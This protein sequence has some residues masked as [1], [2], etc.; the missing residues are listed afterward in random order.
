MKRD[1]QIKNTHAAGKSKKKLQYFFKKKL[2]QL[3]KQNISIN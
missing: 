3:E 1:I 2:W